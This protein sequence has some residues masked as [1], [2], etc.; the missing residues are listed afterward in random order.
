MND[1]LDTLTCP[2]TLELIEDPV[3]LPCCGKSVSR[4]ALIQALEFRDVCPLCRSNL[5]DFDAS[6]APPNRDLISI[7][8]SIQKKNEETEKKKNIMPIKEHQWG[9][10]VEWI[11]NEIQVLVDLILKLKDHISRPTKFYLLP[12]LTI[13]DQCQ[14]PLGDKFRQPSHTY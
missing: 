5:S 2:I 14:D 11:N 13:V 8:E 10:N 4:A 3:Q 12:L 7:I 9:G 1:I 6:Q